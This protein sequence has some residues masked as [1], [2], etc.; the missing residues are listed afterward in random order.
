MEH[1]KGAHMCASG[2]KGL[3]NHDENK[4]LELF[5]AITVIFFYIFAP[6]L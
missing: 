1:E 2:W 6:M 4:P 5:W 3:R